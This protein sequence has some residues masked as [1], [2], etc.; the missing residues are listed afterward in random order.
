MHGF[1]ASVLEAALAADATRDEETQPGMVPALVQ[2]SG[3]SNMLR[4]VGTLSEGF[5]FPFAGSRLPH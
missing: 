5:V 4:T 2:L 3:I 1:F